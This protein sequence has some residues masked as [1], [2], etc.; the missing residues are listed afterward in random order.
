MSFFRPATYTINRNS[1]YPV[2]S[3]LPDE[4]VLAEEIG[5]GCFSLDVAKETIKL[6]YKGLTDTVRQGAKVSLLIPE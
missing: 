1:T 6:Y 3:V 4:R 2:G 5:V